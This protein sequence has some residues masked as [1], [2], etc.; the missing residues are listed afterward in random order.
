MVYPPGMIGGNVAHLDAV[1]IAPRFRKPH[2][3]DTQWTADK[4]VKCGTER[5]T[6]IVLDQCPDNPITD[7][8]IRKTLSRALMRILRTDAFEQR[9]NRPWFVVPRDGLVVM[10]QSSIIR[11]TWPVSVDLIPV[12]RWPI[13]FSAWIVLSARAICNAEPI[14]TTGKSKSISRMTGK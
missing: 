9:F 10:S 4:H 8:G 6:R 13:S 3:F 1:K 14:F 11:K 12:H 5:F 7:V 2:I